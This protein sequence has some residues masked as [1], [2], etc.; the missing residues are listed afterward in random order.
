[1][2]P[3]QALQHIDP[4]PV[5]IPQDDYLRL[6]VERG[7]QDVATLDKLM[8]VRRE[9][10]AERAKVAF[11]SALAGFQSECPV[12]VKRKAV[13]NKDG[14]ATRYRY[15]PLDQIINQVRPLLAKWEFS[16]Q[17]D[18]EVTNDGKLI[19]ATCTITHKLGHSQLSTFPAPI[20][21]EAYMNEPQRF[22]S[23]LTFAKRY[24]FCNAFGIMTG[25]QD[26]DATGVTKTD[27]PAD[28][29]ALKG[30]L[31]SLLKPVRGDADSWFQARQ[32]LVD[33]CCIDPDMPIKDLDADGFR[34]VIAKATERLAR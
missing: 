22:A 9:L 25:D 13:M 32:W 26:D 8:A 29:Q 5:L 23:A 6:A 11:D 33:E 2:N 21:R 27:S 4:D 12:I 17:V 15:A 10:V 18:C 28:R 14:K 3:Q 31:W 16:F 30:Q 19:K 1:M 20:D 7:V 34:A 24:A